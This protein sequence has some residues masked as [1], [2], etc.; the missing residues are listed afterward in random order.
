MLFATCNNGNC[1]INRWS[2]DFHIILISKEGILES[3]VMSHFPSIFF[4]MK[5]NK[6]WHFEFF[7]N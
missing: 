3:E 1:W 7:L 6:Y 2:F 4:I 5:T